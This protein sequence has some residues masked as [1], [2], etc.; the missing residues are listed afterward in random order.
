M[1]KQDKLY[2]YVL[3]GLLEKTTIDSD[4]QRV[5]TP[6]YL[7]SKY[8]SHHEEFMDDLFAGHHYRM[9]GL[10]DRMAALGNFREKVRWDYDKTIPYSF[11]IM[12]EP[13]IS[14]SFFEYLY[15]H[16]LK[17]RS[18]E[19]WEDYVKS[20]RKMISKDSFKFKI[21]ILTEK[22]RR[23]SGGLFKPVLPSMIKM[24]TII[25]NIK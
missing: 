3:D 22:L 8:N 17:D 5:R 21:I 14:K 13:N 2:K 12:I 24:V 16:G 18:N 9:M 6:F 10:D 23:W 11:F 15:Y 7:G 20:V 25:F 1:D 4:T 19:I